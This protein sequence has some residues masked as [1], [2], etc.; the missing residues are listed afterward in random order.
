LSSITTEQLD[1]IV[2]TNLY[3]MF[4]LSKQALPHLKEGA[5]IINT[6]SSKGP[7]SR[8]SCSTTP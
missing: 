4:W 6:S 8:R 2:K 1:G 3:A 5:V 7:S